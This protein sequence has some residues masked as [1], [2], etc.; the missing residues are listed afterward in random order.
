MENR[1]RYAVIGA[2]VLACLLAGFAFVSGIPNTGGMGARAVYAV[3]F[4]EPIGGITTGASVLFN[5]IRVG[6]VSSI[7]LEPND[8]RQVTARLSGLARRPAHRAKGR[9]TRRATADIGKRS[10]AIADRR[11]RRRRKPQR[12][13]THD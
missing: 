13:S 2:F 1:A 3:R 9:T 12:F 11:A 6:A 4:N 8:P 10:A 5:G 7:K